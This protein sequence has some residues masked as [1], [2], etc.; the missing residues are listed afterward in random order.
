MPA[1]KDLW[2]DEHV[3]DWDGLQAALHSEEIVPEWEE[4]GGHRRSSYVFRGMADANWALETSLDRLKSPSEK[5][6]QPA[7]RSFGKYAPQGTFARDSEWERLAVAQHNGLPTRVLDWTVSPL[8]A[9]HFATAEP[10]H[11]ARTASSGA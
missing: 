1:K 5:V 6:E 9:A 2:D 8:V 4:L 11:M 3:D 10:E 7:L